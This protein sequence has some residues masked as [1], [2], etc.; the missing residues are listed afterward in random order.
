MPKRPGQPRVA[1]HF[2][3][4]LCLSRNAELNGHG[5]SV[6]YT[7]GLL[8]LRDCSMRLR[9]AAHTG[10]N[11]LYNFPTLA[12]SQ[13]KLLLYMIDVNHRCEVYICTGER[14][15]TLQ[16]LRGL[17]VHADSSQARHVHGRDLRSYRHTAKCEHCRLLTGYH[18]LHSASHQAQGG[19]DVE[20]RVI[21]A[22]QL[23]AVVLACQGEVI[24]SCLSLSHFGIPPTRS[25]N[26]S[27]HRSQREAEASSRPCRCKNRL[28]VAFCSV[29]EQKIKD[30]QN[31][32][33]TRS[34]HELVLETQL[35][36]S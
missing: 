6:L 12:A 31:Q 30:R 33:P 32:R 4:S 18:S 23:R 19:A 22:L 13:Q 10:H 16:K 27:R 26:P 20:K 25:V 29:D 9:A 7:P 24:R 34:R 8:H 36:M 28:R 21:R 35:P 11:E 14:Q 3:F 15:G 5:A 2:L 17:S 1:Q